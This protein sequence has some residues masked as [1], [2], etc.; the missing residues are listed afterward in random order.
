MLYEIPAQIIRQWCFCPRIVYYRELLNISTHKPLWV[1]QGEKSHLNL[2]SLL[3]RRR[4]AKLGIDKG[5]YHYDCSVRSEEHGINGKVDLIVE[6]ENAVYPFDYKLGA[7]IHRGQIMQ[8]LAYAIMAKEVFNKPV[9]FVTLLYDKKGKKIKTFDVTEENLL[10][11]LNLCEE[12]R[13]MINIGIKPN[14]NASLK[15]CIQ[16]EYL[17]YCNDRGA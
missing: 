1:E 16:C 10:E 13:R 14:S 12:I 6:C 2:K 17:N 3:R 8:M 15:Q 4:F 9:P 11:V 5:R 7:K